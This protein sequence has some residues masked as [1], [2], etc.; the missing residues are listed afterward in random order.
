M[1]LLGMNLVREAAKEQA[2]RMFHVQLSKAGYCIV[3]RA[4]LEIISNT[5]KSVLEKDKE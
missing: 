4:V 3:E 1:Y 2:I 5:V